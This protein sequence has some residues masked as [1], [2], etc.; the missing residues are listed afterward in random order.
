MSTEWLEVMC[1]I[2][3]KWAILSNWERDLLIECSPSTLTKDQQTSLHEIYYER[4]VEEIPG[5]DRQKE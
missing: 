5:R 3:E 2:A 1:S 4:I